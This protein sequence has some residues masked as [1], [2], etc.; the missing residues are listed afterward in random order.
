[1]TQSIQH[2]NFR[3]FYANDLNQSEQLAFK[4]L[5][6]F[7]QP[8]ASTFSSNAEKMRKNVISDDQI[9]L[10]NKS[11][12][13]SEQRIVYPTPINSLLPIEKWLSSC[14]CKIQKASTGLPQTLF[15]LLKGGEVK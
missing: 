4:M 15:K 13:D 9:A 3:I 6:P 7:S 12:N 11:Q 1:M 8:I 14:L 5:S 2:Q 10:A